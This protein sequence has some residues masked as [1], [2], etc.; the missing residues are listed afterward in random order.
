MAANG[1]VY[2]MWFDW[3]ESPTTA[4]GALSSISAV[5]LRRLRHMSWTRLG[6]LSDRTN[7]WSLS[8]SNLVPN[9]ATISGLYVNDAAVYGAWPDSARP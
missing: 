3:R 4:C 5:A 6:A 1:R 8:A 7:D 9:Q 2:V